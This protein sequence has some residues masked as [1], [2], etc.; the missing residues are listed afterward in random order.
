VHTCSRRIVGALS[1]PSESRD[2]IQKQIQLVKDWYSPTKDKGKKIV[3]NSIVGDV[4]KMDPIWTI[5]LYF[6]I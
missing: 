5:I 1:A 4:R 6:G 2:D 3:S